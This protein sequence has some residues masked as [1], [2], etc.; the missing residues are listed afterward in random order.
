MTGPG[1][2][3]AVTSS[4]PMAGPVDAAGHAETDLARAQAFAGAS[5]T[6]FFT[7]MKITNEM[8]TKSMKDPAKSP[9]PNLTLPMVHVA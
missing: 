2:G 9:M 1:P 4:A 7:I 3:P 6:R 5:F 8:M